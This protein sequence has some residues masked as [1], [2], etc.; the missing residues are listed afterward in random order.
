MLIRQKKAFKILRQHV[1]CDIVFLRKYQDNYT[2][3]QLRSAIIN[4][5]NP[6][7]SK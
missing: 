3:D 4:S 2:L 1:L 7:K 6:M 5:S